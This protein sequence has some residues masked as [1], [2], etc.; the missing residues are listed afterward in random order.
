MV[1]IRQAADVKDTNVNPDESDY[2]RY[3]NIFNEA[4]E[5]NEAARR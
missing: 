1:I 4:K 3:L 5:K 2:M